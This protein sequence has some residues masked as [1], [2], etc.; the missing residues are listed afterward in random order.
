[1]RVSEPSKKLSTKCPARR[2]SDHRR[3]GPAGQ[4]GLF[5]FVGVDDVKNTLNNCL[6]L[7]ELLSLIIW[8]CSFSF[9]LFSTAGVGESDSNMMFCSVRQENDYIG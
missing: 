3:L 1:M 8:A 9:L 6:R 4:E 2:G 7:H 5:S